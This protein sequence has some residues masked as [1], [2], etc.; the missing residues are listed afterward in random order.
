MTQQEDKE[1]LR[2]FVE[3]KFEKQN[4][5]INLFV[6]TMVSIFLAFGVLAAT[7]L[8]GDARESGEQNTQ[9]ETILKL[10]ESTAQNIKDLTSV[11]NTLV[12]D[13]KLREEE[14]KS[15][16]ECLEGILS[17]LEAAEFAVLTNDPSLII[18]ARKAHKSVSD[19][20]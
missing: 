4:K 14:Q 8:V 17:R 13:G 9:I 1:D 12:T 20:N 6:T 19:S 18:E 10:Q 15:I 16:L 7:L 5:K 2:L 11:V 3:E